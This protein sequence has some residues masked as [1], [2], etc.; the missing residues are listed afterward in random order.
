MTIFLEKINSLFPGGAIYSII[1]ESSNTFLLGLGLWDR[2][3]EPHTQI[4]KDQTPGQ[5]VRIDSDNR[6]LAKSPE[7]NNIIYQLQPLDDGRVFVGCRDSNTYYLN[8]DLTVNRKINIPCGGLYFW[9]KKGNNIIAT[10]RS[11]GLIY[12]NLEDDSCDVLPLV[13]SNVRMWALLLDGENIIC[14]SYDGDLIW[15][16]ER[17]IIK[18][19]MIEEKRNS[20]W[21]IEKFGNFYWVGTANGNIYIFDRNLSNGKIVHQ[22]KVGLKNYGITCVTK[23]L[24]QLIFG[25]IHGNIHFFNPDFSVKDFDFNLKCKTPNTIWWIDSSP[26]QNLIRVAYCNGSLETFKVFVT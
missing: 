3:N 14:G 26:E 24:D 6:I 10:M 7:L 20:I 25:D 21:A 23:Y 11:G 9:H 19:F 22:N 8:H 5:V 1:K 13:N 17:K 15:V 12:F 16:K 18:K 4:I 2:E